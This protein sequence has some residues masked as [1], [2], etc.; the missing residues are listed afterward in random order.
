MLLINTE[1]RELPILYTPGQLMAV[2][3]LSKQRWRTIRAALPPLDS[4]PGHAPCFS[5][6]HFVAVGVA[7]VVTDQLGSPLSTLTPVA[8]GLFES[9]TNVPWFQLERSQISIIPSER[10]VELLAT[11]AARGPKGLELLIALEPITRALRERL[12]DVDVDPQHNLAFSPVIA[13]GQRL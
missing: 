2:F 5:A 3:G 12:L 10:K 13:A 1:I 8:F 4:G 6:G 9:C 11:D 7:K